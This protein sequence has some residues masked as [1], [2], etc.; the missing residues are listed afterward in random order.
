MSFRARLTLVAAAA[1][2]LAVVAASA[3][4]YV[5]V[6]NELRSRVDNDLRSRAAG[7]TSNNGPGPGPG[8]GGLRLET[9]PIT[10]KQYVEVSQAVLG[11]AS[12]IQ[13]VG[14]NGRTYRTRTETGSLPVSKHALAVA[15][16]RHHQS[17]Q[18]QARLPRAGEC[19][20]RVE[21]RYHPARRKA[22]LPRIL[23]IP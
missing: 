9:D 1:V 8:G 16:G 23:S 11:P 15:S 4:V 5:V 6:R 19:R 2:A 14:S 18:G 7:I 3:V 17:I 12:Y 21:Y 13:I 10:G 20:S 22:M